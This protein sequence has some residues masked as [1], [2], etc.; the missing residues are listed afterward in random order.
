M[1]TTKALGLIAGTSAALALAP[2]TFAA[3]NPFGL[4]DA[5][6]SAIVVAEVSRDKSI[7]VLE[8]KCGAGKCGTSRVRQMMD[9]NAD[10]MISREE[11]VG[12]STSQA[13]D[14][15]DKFAG[16]KGAVTADDVYQHFLSLTQGIG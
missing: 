9:R 6:S 13:A 7:S 11:Y 14:E 16:N 15:F 2:A 8:G 1:K 3:E 12:W 10:G 5:G 4:K